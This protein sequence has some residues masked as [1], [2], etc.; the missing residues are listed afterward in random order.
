MR[1]HKYQSCKTVMLGTLF[2]RFSLLPSHL[3][4]GCLEPAALRGLPLS[5]KAGECLEPTV[6]CRSPAPSGPL[7]GC[8]ASAQGGLLKGVA[9]MLKILQNP[10]IL[11]TFAP[12]GGF[13]LKISKSRHHR[14]KKIQM[15][16]HPMKK[17]SFKLKQH[18]LELTVC[19]VYCVCLR[20]SDGD[21]DGWIS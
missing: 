19:V 17:K 12:F 18:L 13:P 16:N 4:G 20:S 7:T 10:L 15:K 5:R 14:T 2:A 3:E 8:K 9:K 1:I 21:Q 6:L 11:S